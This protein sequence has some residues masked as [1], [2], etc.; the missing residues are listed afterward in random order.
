[1]A[2]EKN[3]VGNSELQGFGLVCAACDAYNAWGAATCAA[4]QQALSWQPVASQGQQNAAHASPARSMKSSVRE[5]ARA[6]H[7]ASMPPSQKAKEDNSM[8]QARLYVCKECGNH[9]QKGYKFCGACGAAVPAGM[10]GE[11]VIQTFASE[12]TQQRA[13]LLVI[14]GVGQVDGMSYWLGAKESWI[15]RAN[16]EI[17]FPDDPWVSSRHARF[18]YDHDDLYIS[19]E[20]S[21]NGVFVRVHEPVRLAAGDHFLCGEQLF[22]VEM[23]SSDDVVPAADGTLFYASPQRPSSF[24]VVQVLEGGAEGMVFCAKDNTVHIGRV[25]CDMN[26]A[27]DSYMSG[28]HAK[29]ELAGGQA[30]T[31]SDLGSKNGSFVRVK[32]KHKLVSQDH[33]FIGKQLLR[34]E[35]GA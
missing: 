18:F 10:Q 12:Q 26:F 11:P 35:F 25:E 5:D 23:A 4:C 21:A 6:L 29:V 7:W 33:I 14:R 20:A 30:F 34:I 16:A 32:G 13:R 3:I 8:E 28:R 9:V 24:R 1:M 17:L 2:L 31:L 19:D 22:R 15:G 27:E